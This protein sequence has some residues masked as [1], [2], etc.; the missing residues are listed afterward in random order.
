VAEH[1][2]ALRG[3][4]EG[5]QVLFPLPIGNENEASDQIDKLLVFAPLNPTLVYVMMHPDNARPLV[6]FIMSGMVHLQVDS[7]KLLAYPLS[8]PRNHKLGPG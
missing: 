4:P 6:G 1:D 7:L 5:I 3:Q 8:Q 2:A